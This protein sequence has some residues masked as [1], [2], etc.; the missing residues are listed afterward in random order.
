IF[1]VNLPIGLTGILLAFRYMP[2]Y[3]AARPAP[4]DF[5]GL[6]LFASGIGLLSYV[7][8]VFGEHALTVA[9]E[10]S[11]FSVALLLL[12]AYGIHA[13]RQPFPLLQLSLF[14]VRTFRVSVIGG[15]I[16][17]LGA[18]GMPF[19]LPLLYQIGLGYSPVQSGLLIMPQPLA[20]IGL[21]LFT[22]RILARF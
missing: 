1:F 5:V 11:L 9:S 13:T 8:E 2:D 18:G 10:I 16:T 17:R 15:F 14:R 12:A 7:L 21:R 20:A 6:V 3:R 22:P 19:M 4:L